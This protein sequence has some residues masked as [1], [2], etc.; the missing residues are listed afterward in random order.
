MCTQTRLLSGVSS[1]IGTQTRLLIG[2]SSLIFSNCLDPLPSPVLYRR[3]GVREYIL[4]RFLLRS[5]TADRARSG[6]VAGPIDS[7][8]PLKRTGKYRGPGIFLTGRC[9]V[10]ART[11]AARLLQRVEPPILPAVEH[12]KL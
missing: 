3:G 6:A 10:C 4:P 9:V 8:T 2:V 1:L 7:F 12:C 5:A 11:G